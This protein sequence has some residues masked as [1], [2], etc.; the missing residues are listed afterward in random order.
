MKLHI[1]TPTRQYEIEGVTRVI[2]EA[3]NGSFC[4]LPRHTDFLSALVPGLLMYERPSGEEVFLAADSGLLVKR[5]GDVLVAVRRAIAGTDLESL[6]STVDR[7]FAN[8]DERSRICQSAIASL[9]ANFLRRFLDLES[10][11]F[12]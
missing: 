9:E 10:R 1:H 11:Q 4:L 6:R 3:A 8:L 2:A 5:G 7:E 12:E